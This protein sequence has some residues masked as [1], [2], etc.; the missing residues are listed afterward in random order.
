[1]RYPNAPSD[2]I[3]SHARRRH[4]GEVTVRP[5]V[6]QS[7]RL[8]TQARVPWFANLSVGAPRQAASGL[9]SPTAASGLVRRPPAAAAG[10]PRV[11]SNPTASLLRTP[12]ATVPAV[13]R[14][15]WL[16]SFAHITLP[17]DTPCA[18]GA[19]SPPRRHGSDSVPSSE[20]F[21]NTWSDIHKNLSRIYHCSKTKFLDL[22]AEREGFEP[23]VPREGQLISSRP[24]SA[25]PAPLRA[26][27]GR[28]AR[29]AVW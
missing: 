10:R 3:A 6:T 21:S 22:L 4:T 27:S 9:P 23:A 1:M 11:T 17:C 7:Y 28:P 15:L 8:R 26:W 13:L 2:A 18:S 25:T 16:W 12:Y 14:S 19:V 24:R 29:G 20:R 5:D